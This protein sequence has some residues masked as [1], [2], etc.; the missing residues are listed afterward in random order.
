MIPVQHPGGVIFPTAR[1][2]AVFRQNR[3]HSV[4]YAIV[5]KA[6]FNFDVTPD[7]FKLE[8]SKG[9]RVLDYRKKSDSPDYH[10]ALSASLD[11][12]KLNEFN[13]IPGSV[14]CSP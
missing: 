9:D 11:V 1:I 13:F 7:A 6:E 12:L 10:T 14:I 5:S 4:A 2:T 3:L 8:A